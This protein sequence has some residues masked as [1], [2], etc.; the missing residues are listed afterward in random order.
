[1]SNSN[2]KLIWSCI[3]LRRKKRKLSTVKC[4]HCRSGNL[5]IREDRQGR[6]FLGCSNYPG[7]DKKFND[8]RLL[9]SPINC[10]RCGGYLV[11]RRSNY[12]L[13]RGVQITQI[14]PILI[15]EIQDLIDIFNK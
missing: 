15:R 12:G 6:K 13:L 5:A 10:P 11:E 1:M 7:C 9:N 14:V 8:V 3:F 4:P 2:V